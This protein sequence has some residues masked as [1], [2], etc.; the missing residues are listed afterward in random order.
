MEDY[1]TVYLPA[2]G[3][4]CH[5]GN[6][7]CVKLPS[8]ESIPNVV[9]VQISATAGEVVEVTVKMLARVKTVED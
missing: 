8:G 5:T 2:P 4:E 3:R 9:D 6:G 7:A 1:C